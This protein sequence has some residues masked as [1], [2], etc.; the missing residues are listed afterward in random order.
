MGVVD[1]FEAGKEV[2]VNNSAV[3]IWLV[4][5]EWQKMSPERPLGP[6]SKRVLVTRLGS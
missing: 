4:V 1:A 6:S 2:V 3:K 5:E